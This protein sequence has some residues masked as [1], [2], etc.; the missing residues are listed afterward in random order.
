MELKTKITRYDY[1]NLWH[2]KKKRSPKTFYACRKQTQQQNELTVR[3]SMREIQVEET[4]VTQTAQ[5]FHALQLELESAEFECGRVIFA[6]SR[7]QMVT[8][9]NL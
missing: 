6:C 9:F 1:K 4:L 8:S 2:S 7:W 3:Y 5:R